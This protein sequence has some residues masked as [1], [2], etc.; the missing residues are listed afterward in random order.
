MITSEPQ[1]IDIQKL[2]S[3]GFHAEVVSGGKI[4]THED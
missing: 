1:L 4:E 3:S 2:K